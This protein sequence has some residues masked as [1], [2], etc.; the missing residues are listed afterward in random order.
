MK[1]TSS[2]INSMALEYILGPMAGSTKAV[3]G[4]ASSMGWALTLAW[5]EKSRRKG[6]GRMGR[7]FYEEAILS[8]NGRL[9]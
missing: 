8:I 4:K 1:G 3:G 7:E 9:P 2:I 5:L 6:S